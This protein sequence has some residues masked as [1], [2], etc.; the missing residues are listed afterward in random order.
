MHQLQW[1]PFF[2][3]SLKPLRCRVEFPYGPYSPVGRQRL[4]LMVLPEEALKFLLARE[5]FRLGAR[6][7]DGSELFCS[8]RARAMMTVGGMVGGLYGAYQTAYILNR[9]FKLPVRWRPPSRLLLYTGL[10]FLGLLCQWQFA[11]AVRRHICFAVDRLAGS[12]NSSFLHGGLIYYDWRIRWNTFWFDRSVGFHENNH[13]NY[14]ATGFFNVHQDGIEGMHQSNQR[15]LGFGGPKPSSAHDL[16]TGY[17]LPVVSN[18]SEG[19]THKQTS[20]V[21]SGRFTYFTNP[22]VSPRG[23]ELWCGDGDG[24]S[25]GLTE[26][27]ELGLVPSVVAWF[28]SLC[29]S[30]ATSRMRYARMAAALNKTE[31]KAQ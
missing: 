17:Y 15:Q 28:F 12:L 19:Q 1:L 8:S 6:C 3:P 5:L 16:E 23:N 14:P 9:A 20:L 25:F 24:F 18:A 29:S 21:R 30:P 2:I 22:R 27:L 31:Y 13:K 26:F 11:L 4:E 7:L 10:A